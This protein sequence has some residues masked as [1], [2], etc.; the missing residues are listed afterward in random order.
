[1]LCVYVWCSKLNIYHKLCKLEAIV[2]DGVS[3]A[4]STI[5]HVCNLDNIVANECPCYGD[6]NKTCVIDT[7]LLLSSVSVIATTI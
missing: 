2:S 5:K 3:I 6:R 4:V 1:M 7:A